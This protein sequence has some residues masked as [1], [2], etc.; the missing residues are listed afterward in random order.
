[1]GAHASKVIWGIGADDEE[2]LKKL[3]SRDELCFLK[4]KLDEG[5]SPPYY[6]STGAA[7]LDLIAKDD[8]TLP[9]LFVSPDEPPAKDILVKVDT[10]CAFELP[11]L[12]YGQIQGRSGLA[13]KGIFVHPGI[14]DSDFR[15]NVQVLMKNLGHEP[16]QIKKGDRIAQMLILPVARPEIRIVDFLSDTKRGDG[17]F[18]STGVA[19]AEIEIPEDKKQKTSSAD[20]D[21]MHESV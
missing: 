14:I 9:S 7:A 15:G 19:S 21:Q 6:A 20:D 18:G 1:M 12:L 2:E 4:C 10:G 16:Y 5:A 8:A 3:P 13:K 17:G 11:F